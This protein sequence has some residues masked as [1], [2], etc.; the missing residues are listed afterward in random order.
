MPSTAPTFF[1]RVTSPKINNGLMMQPKIATPIAIFE[2][3]SNRSS[4]NHCQCWRGSRGI[5]KDW[6]VNLPIPNNSI[7]PADKPSTSWAASCR[8]IRR[9]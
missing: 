8:S 9:R 5:K 1:Q 3:S 6:R 2:K 7:A 4:D